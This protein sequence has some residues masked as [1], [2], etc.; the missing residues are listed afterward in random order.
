[1]KFTKILIAAL[2]AFLAGGVAFAEKPEEKPTVHMVAN[3][4]FDT[5]WRWTAHTA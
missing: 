2:L 4:H 1:M 3:A 5:Q